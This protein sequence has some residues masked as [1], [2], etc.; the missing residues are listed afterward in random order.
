MNLLTLV[1]GWLGPNFAKFAKPLIYAVL[2]LLAVVAI[3]VAF[4]VHDHRVIAANN[5]KIE[6]RAKPATDQA[7]TERANDTIAIQQ[8]E[9]E[10]H[11]AVHS[12]PDA[13]SAGPSHALQCQRLRKLGRSVAACS[14][15]ASGH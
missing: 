12:V 3:V 8:N 5:A 14:R 9:T 7:A 2:T 15:P 11:N 10:A 13:A 1:E 6:A 4:R